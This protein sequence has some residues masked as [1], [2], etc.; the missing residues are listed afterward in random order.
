MERQPGLTLKEGMSEFKSP[1]VCA[2]D[3]KGLISHSSPHQQRSDKVLA[4]ASRFSG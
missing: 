4:L 2:E 1:G 3:T